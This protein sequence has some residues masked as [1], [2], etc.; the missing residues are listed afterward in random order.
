MST[1]HQKY[2]IPYQLASIAQYAVAREI[3]IVKTYED[4]GK[5]GLRLEGREGLKRL[6]ADVKSGCADFDNVLVYDVS[7]WGRF[8]DVDESAYYEFI[9]KQA[10]IAVHYCAEQFDNT[11]GSLTASVLKSIKRV[12]AGEYSRELSVK[13]FASQLRTC[14]SGF[15][16][17]GLAGYGLRRYLVDKHGNRKAELFPGER[18]GFRSDHVILVPGPKEEIETVQRIY[19]LFVNENLTESAIVRTLNKDG[20]LTEQGRAWTN[21]KVHGI[22]TKE[23][24]IGNYLYNRQ[25]RKL[26]TKLVTNPPEMWVR[27]IGVFEPIVSADLFAAAQKKIAERSVKMTDAEMIEPLKDILRRHGTLSTD[28]VNADTIAPSTRRYKERFGSL[29]RAWELAGYKP[30]HKYEHLE[31]RHQLRTLAAAVVEDII[32]NIER[33]GGAARFDR[34]RNRIEI[35]GELT[36]SIVPM[37]C[38]TSRSRTPQWQIR[39]AAAPTADILIGLRMKQSNTDILDYFLL[40]RIDIRDRFLLLHQENRSEIETYRCSTLTPFCELCARQSIGW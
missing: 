23:K 19:R 27:Y 17:G 2:S 5:S 12:M 1:G 18:K 37:Y 13:V 39:L 25:S 11:D 24:Y 4:A 30:K 26:H 32:E 8:Q 3:A 7:R 16:V 15:K 22:L 20:I 29:L 21:I 6:I 31:K 36:V 38:N 10:G 14:A 28:L 9:C 35:N 33:L 40:P 34:T